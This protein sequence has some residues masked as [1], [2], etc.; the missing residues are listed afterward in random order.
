M[1]GRVKERTPE[2]KQEAVRKEKERKL[3]GF[4]TLWKDI[5]DRRAEGDRSSET[6]MKTNQLLAKC[7]DL[8]TLW[9]YRREIL[10]ADLTDAESEEGKRDGILRIELS[11][12][13]S[14]LALDFKSYSTWYHRKWTLEQM[15]KADWQR[16]LDLTSQLFRLDAR[17][18]HC[19]NYRRFIVERGHIPLSSE[20]A[21]STKLIADD[22]SNYSAW[23]YRT[24]LI[25]LLFPTVPSPEHQTQ[26]RTELALV[27]TAVN[28]KANDQ[29]IW[30]YTQFLVEQIQKGGYTNLL[31][32]LKEEVKKLYEEGDLT[33]EESIAVLHGYVRLLLLDP[34]QN[35]KESDKKFVDD[36]ID[37]LCS[38]DPLRKGYYQSLRDAL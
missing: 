34:I 11:V 10:L 33:A 5:V 23:H 28:V 8:Y 13:E 20:L 17:N 26:I 37:K 35:L 30:F 21:F 4:T 27:V 22:P 14:C 38:L 31:D 3:L 1:H 18:F 9:N 24:T 36:S 12:T 19:W 7:S 32:E 25:P 2:E 29:G 16:E 15:Q 6:L